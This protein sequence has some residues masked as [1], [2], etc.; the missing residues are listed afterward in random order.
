[1]SLTLTVPVP[2]RPVFPARDQPLQFAFDGGVPDVLV[3]QYGISVSHKAKHVER[4][5][6]RLNKVAIAIL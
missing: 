3:L 5:P 6:H 2:L 1:M 4:L